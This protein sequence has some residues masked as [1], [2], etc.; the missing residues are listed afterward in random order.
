MTGSYIIEM[1]LANPPYR[2]KQAESAQ[3]MAKLLGYDARATKRLERI[4]KKTNIEY[5]HTILNPEADYLPV[6]MGGTSERL[7]IYEKNACALALASIREGISP[8]FIPKITHLITVS[9]TGMYAPGLDIELLMQL[10]LSPHIERTCINFMGCYGAFNALKVADAICQKDAGA[11]VMIVCVEFCSL[12]FQPINSEENLIANALFA[13]GAACAL[14]HSQP[15]GEKNLNLTGFRSGLSEYEKKA[16]TWFIGNHGFDI[17]LSTYVPMILNE[18]VK[19]LVHP[20]LAFFQLIL[21]QIDF[22]AIHPG[23]KDILIQVEK[24]LSIPAEKNK[25]AHEIL[26]DYGNM[27]SPTILFVLKKLLS[28]L[29]TKNNGQKILGMA[30]GPGLTI[31]SGLLEIYIPEKLLLE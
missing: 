26:K 23:G 21:E 19:T 11:L 2:L 3:V 6:P 17:K 15:I 8:R 24:A 28:R 25:E 31:E 29:T 16:M 5:R 27:S 30:F 7:K 20:L 4:Y 14:V 10:H 18:H 22:F 1:G 9:C 13:D 12:H